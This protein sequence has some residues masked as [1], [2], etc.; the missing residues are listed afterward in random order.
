[1]TDHNL[2][3]GFGVIDHHDHLGVHDPGRGVIITTHDRREDRIRQEM[4]DEYPFVVRASRDQTALFT[5][6][7]A[8][9]DA[10]EAKVVELAEKHA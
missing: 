3:D 5:G 7:F 9:A 6:V 8:D 10:A 2:P 1:M 4:A